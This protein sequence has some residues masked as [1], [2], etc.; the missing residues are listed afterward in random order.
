MTST[1]VYERLFTTK[2]QKDILAKI[3]IFRRAFP[4]SCIPEL[5]SEYLFIDFPKWHSNRKQICN[6]TGIV[7]LVNRSIYSNTSFGH[8]EW[9]LRFYLQYITEYWDRETGLDY[10]IEQK[11]KILAISTTYCKNC[12]EPVCKK[13]IC[14]Q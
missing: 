6:N 2:Y 4:G 8:F 13:C 12:G 14:I 3:L 9:S 10:R 1:D 7:K 11:L 5:L